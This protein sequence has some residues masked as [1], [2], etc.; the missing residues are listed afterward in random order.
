MS[1]SNGT[2]VGWELLRRHDGAHVSLAV[3]K[4]PGSG[5]I[6]PHAYSLQHMIGQPA[7]ERT[8]VSAMADAIAAMVCQMRLGCFD[9]MFQHCQC[10]P[11]VFTSTFDL[12][13]C[14]NHGMAAGAVGSLKALS[15]DREHDL[16]PM[17][18][19]L[20]LCCAIAHGHAWK[21]KA[22]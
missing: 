19:R 14:D 9:D 22:G 5:F 2:L 17:R 7:F 15:K 20:M 21:A 1:V 3:R 13:E 16:K 6:L 8:A 10:T 18:I 4:D 11:C 12:R